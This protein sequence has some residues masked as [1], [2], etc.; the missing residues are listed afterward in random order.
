MSS[1]RRGFKANESYVQSLPAPPA[2]VYSSR[3]GL[4]L[5]SSSHRVFVML[6]TA[7]KGTSEISTS[8]SACAKNMS[9]IRK[10]LLPGLQILKEVFLGHGRKEVSIIR[11]D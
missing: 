9:H 1:I 8:D 4:V 3:A 2:I 7:F 11:S 5:H 10:I 6:C